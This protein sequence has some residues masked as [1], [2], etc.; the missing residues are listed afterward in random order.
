M[1]AVPKSITIF[2]GD[3][4][5]LKNVVNLVEKI[6]PSHFEKEVHKIFRRAWLPVV[7]ISDLPQRGSYVAVYVPPV[8]AS[9]LVVRGQDDVVRAFYNICRHRG[10]KLV[11][12]GEK[13][14][15]RAFTCPFHA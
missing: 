13:G 11:N 9:V 12:D 7:S 8:K 6:Q 3:T 14:C 4:S 5:D 2:K 15:T 1:S 10:N